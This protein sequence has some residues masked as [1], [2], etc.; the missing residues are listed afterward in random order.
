MVNTIGAQTKYPRK[1]QKKI[2][3]RQESIFGPLACLKNMS[4][5]QVMRFYHNFHKSSCKTDWVCTNH[6][7][8]K[9]LSIYP[10]NNFTSQISDILLS[11]SPGPSSMF[12]HIG[13]FWGQNQSNS[14]I[15]SLFP[16]FFSN[17][18]Y[19]KSIQN[20]LRTDT[21]RFGAKN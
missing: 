12:A 21:N 2:L 10:F 15:P 9:R 8:R 13:H 14:N 11:G 19:L 18:I 7:I 17:S 6:N 3:G 16:I 1:T 4:P 20:H 5:F